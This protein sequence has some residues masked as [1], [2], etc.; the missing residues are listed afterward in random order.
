M[1]EVNLK[2]NSKLNKEQK[3]K[4]MKRKANET[5]CASEIWEGFDLF[6]GSGVVDRERDG[7]GYVE[8]DYKDE[9]DAPCG[10]VP[11]DV[12]VDVRLCKYHPH[13]KFVVCQ[14]P[15]SAQ[16]ISRN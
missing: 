3:R 12:G 1:K 11:A 13:Q 5:Q 9:R 10:V 16:Q 4:M 15:P 14:F 2:L 6:D 8:Y 7:S